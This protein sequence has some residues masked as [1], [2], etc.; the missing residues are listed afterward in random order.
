[1]SPRLIRLRRPPVLSVQEGV[2]VPANADLDEIEQRW[3]SFRA[4]HPAAFDGR[5]C[6]VLGVHRNGHGG[7]SI[8]VIDCAYRFHAV[9]LDLGVRPL[10]VKG[11]TMRD[12][13]VLLGRRSSSVL[14]YPGEWEFAPGGVVEPGRSPAEALLS[15]LREETGLSAAGDPTPVAV[16]FDPVART[17][18][19]VF[20]VEASGA[21]V[22][23]HTNEYD[24]LGWSE[25]RELPEP[26]SP[27]AKQM[28]FL[29]RSA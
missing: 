13:R 2:F 10:G 22:Q 27:V 11:I 15:E 29:L 4:S 17:W 23:P 21:E 28:R 8:H 1:M 7:A 14:H 12:N 20:R 9:G 26:L 6:H 18:E 5:I 16:L 24:E 19:I 3:Q 25:P